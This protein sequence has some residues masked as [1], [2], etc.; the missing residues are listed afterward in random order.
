[1]IIII[2][3]DYAERNLAAKDDLVKLQ[4]EVSALDAEWKEHWQR[5]QESDQQQQAA[6]NVSP[7][8]NIAARVVCF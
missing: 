3:I 6:F 1:L 8:Q 7:S 4:E 5:Y 2:L